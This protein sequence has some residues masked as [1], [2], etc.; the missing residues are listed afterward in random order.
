MARI[1]DRKRLEEMESNRDE[2]KGKFEDV[3]KKLANDYSTDGWESDDSKYTEYQKD[4]LY[5]SQLSR[6]LKVA[7]DD[8]DRL[9]TFRP[10]SESNVSKRQEY[11]E[12]AFRRWLNG[13]EL[14]EPEQKEFIGTNI[15]GEVFNLRNEVREATRSDGSSGEAL[16][17]DMLRPQVIDALD[18]HGGISRM[19]QVFTTSNG[20][21]LRIPTQ[22]DATK[23]GFLLD[24]QDTEIDDDPMSDFDDIVFGAQTMN[25]GA[26]P[27]TREMLVDS[28]IDIAS[29]ATRQVGR[30]MSKG[31]D[32]EFTNGGTIPAE[33]DGPFASTKAPKLDKEI[34]GV[35]KIAKNGLTT[36]TV[37]KI[38]YEDLVDMI[39]EL[40]TAYR[41]GYEG[42]NGMMPL[43]G[44]RIG[45]LISS[46]FEKTIRKLVDG[47]G[48]PLW[49]SMT[50]GL[51]SSAMSPTILDYP[52]EL[53]GNLPEV[54]TG[55]APALFGDFSYYAIRRV[56]GIQI[57]RFMDSR[58]MRRNRIEITGFSRC[59]GRSMF[60]GIPLQGSTAQKTKYG[61]IPQIAKM[62][63]K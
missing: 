38:T 16:T 2:I 44:G 50:S 63:I 14:G 26:M 61:G 10:Q 1:W 57:F 40:D 19:C 53:S 3:S 46:D 58:T 60:P 5:H 30:R 11:T 18:F 32:D 54:K 43:R 41:L 47:D 49:Q 7:N 31:W 15:K 8:I 20:N 56:L 37:G 23:K 27:I 24:R 52:Y 25:S 6:E 34:I 28:A 45:W 29:Y 35:T 22:D 17:D 12:E 48:R 4:Q 55:N 33:I 51:G 59:F 62:I 13:D 39:Y 21:D 36:K 42:E 9:N